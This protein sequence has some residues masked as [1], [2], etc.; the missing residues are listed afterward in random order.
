MCVYAR[1]RV[2]VCSCA[3]RAVRGRGF[4]PLF[5]HHHKGMRCPARGKDAGTSF[6]VTHRERWSQYMDEALTEVGV[7]PTFKRLIMDRSHYAMRFYGPFWDDRAHVAEFEAKLEAEAA[8][9]EQ[10]AALAGSPSDVKSTN[11][12][13]L[14]PRRPNSSRAPVARSTR[15]QLRAPA[16]RPKSRGSDVM[17]GWPEGHHR[18]P[19]NPP[20][21]V[22]RRRL[23]VGASVRTHRAHGRVLSREARAPA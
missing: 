16:T 7:S 9:K 11:Q 3:H 14:G 8:A 23:P 22:R 17:G 2:C 4:H 15:R 19:P 13:T 20:S 18:R 10:A 21:R 6:T 1:A 12:P 5:V